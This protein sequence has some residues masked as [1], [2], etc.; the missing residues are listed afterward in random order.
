MRVILT[1]LAATFFIQL[2]YFLWKMS[3][4]GQPRIGV[5]SAASI[6]KALLT[7]VR[8]LAGL[9][10]TIAG[11]A[12]FVQATSI[13]EISVVQPLMSAGDV[14]LILFAV[15][16]LKERMSALEW[17]GV[18]LTVVGA[19]GLSL[20]AA[21]TTG[22]R[23]SMA[24]LAA[25]VL[26]ATLLFSALVVA[27]AR[28]RRA[29]LMWPL[30]IGIAFGAGAVL[31]EALTARFM[32]DGREGIWAW[33]LALQ[34]LLVPVILANAAGLVLLQAAF[35]R[36]RA[37]VIVPVQLAAANATTVVAAVWLFNESVGAARLLAILVIVLGG[38]LL[39][40]RGR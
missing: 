24:M 25:M 6:A 39:H 5:A 26:V 38:A 15:L 29:E 3:A 9:G 32:A 1:T 40:L 28:W 12:L 20:D 7:D 2:G 27:G 14:L 30:A 13:G 21:E 22:S 17:G 35:Q 37:S 31:T 4:E 11:W 33:H 16:L 36:G 18:S 23:F 10:A 19:V 34:P 8:W